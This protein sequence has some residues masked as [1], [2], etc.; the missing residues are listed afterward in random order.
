MI[1]FFAIKHGHYLYFPLPWQPI[2]HSARN[3][4]QNIIKCVVQWSEGC[5]TLLQCVIRNAISSSLP[6]RSLLPTYFKKSSGIHNR[7]LL[8]FFVIACWCCNRTYPRG[9]SVVQ[10]FGKR[11]EHSKFPNSPV[12]VV[13][14]WFVQFQNVFCFTKH[15]FWIQRCCQ[16]VVA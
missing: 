14:P 9:I 13:A 7:E 1:L 6:P 8:M 3:F 4:R 15:F 5:H 12:S 16:L 10:S 11:N 2:Y